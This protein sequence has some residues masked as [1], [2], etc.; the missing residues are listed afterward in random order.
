MKT[1]T[2]LWFVILLVAVPFITSGLAANTGS[3]T[4]IVDGSAGEI[5][6]TD[7]CP[8]PRNNGVYRTVQ[9]AIDCAVAGDILDI[10]AGTYRE[11]LTIGK[12]LSLRGVGR[13]RTVLDAEN[14]GR[15]IELADHLTLNVSYLALVNGSADRGGALFTNAST[16]N[17]SYVTIQGNSASDIGGAIA[18]E[19]GS[20]NLAYSELNSNSAANLGGAIATTTGTVQITNSSVWGNSAASGGGLY[21][22]HASLILRNTTV[23]G[24]SGGGA[25]TQIGTIRANN[26]TFAN[27]GTEISNA[28]GLVTIVNTLVAGSCSGTLT[29][30]GY[31]LIQIPCEINGDLTGNLYNADPQLRPLANLFGFPSTHALA[32]TSPALNTGSPTLCEPIDQRGVARPQGS[33]CDIGAFEFGALPPI[34]ANPSELMT[35]GNM[36]TYPIRPTFDWIHRV[37]EDAETIPDDAWYNLVLVHLGDDGE[38]AIDANLWYEGQ[39]IC[40]G[41][42]CSVTPDDGVLPYG[43]EAG[44]PVLPIGLLNASYDWYVSVYIPDAGIGDYVEGDGFSINRP[45]PQVVDLTSPVH[46]ISISMGTVTLEWTRDPEA[47]WYSVYLVANGEIKF[48]QWVSSITHCDT[49]LCSLPDLDLP[50]GDFAVYMQAWGPGG[51]GEFNL[52]EPVI[53]HY[54]PTVD[55]ISPVHDVTVVNAVD[56]NVTFTWQSTSGVE[57]YG[58]RVT[59]ASAFD[60]T[61]WH[62]GTD[63]CSNDTCSASMQLVHN[64]D[65]SW[66]VIPYANESIGSSG[67]GTN[68]TLAVPAPDGLTL[69]QPQG[70]L[71]SAS[72]QFVWSPDSNLGYYNLL[73]ESTNGQVHNQWYAAHEICASGMCIVNGSDIMVANGVYHWWVNGWSPY[74]LYDGSGRKI[75]FN[76]NLAAPNAITTIESILS[77]ET[78]M[79][80]TRI[81]WHAD[82]QASWYRIVLTG[83]YSM[84][85]WFSASQVCDNS[86][87][88]SLALKLNPG[89]YEWYIMGAGPGGLGLWSSAVSLNLAP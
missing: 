53:F 86:G 81:V 68:F 37:T 28:A 3:A 75:T 48:S 34:A 36:S 66:S 45:Q 40:S 50:F 14:K 54:G 71:T 8:M 7:A 46:E 16:V 82:N 72:I 64:G 41:T 24:N 85:Q 13:F 89:Q 58:L 21:S 38:L 87:V 6:P 18:S 56:G 84:D 9:K 31:N 15:V 42:A 30:A 67:P 10:K 23:S 33:H 39:D 78:M 35:T 52:T 17:L 79:N 62:R 12:D 27:N 1:R 74:G 47:G 57:Y 51:F 29:S 70:T 19:A 44:D 32:T 11:N 88:C 25:V 76:L 49:L 26:V 5:M 73:V 60:Q 55:L 63:V 59:G 80:E 77:S 83:D 65:Y 22:D 2:F 43:F 61:D 4:L 20:I 69:T